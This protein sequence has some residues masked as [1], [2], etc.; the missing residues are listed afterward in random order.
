MQPVFQLPHPGSWQPPSSRF[1]SFSCFHKSS[2]V[3]TKRFIFLWFRQYLILTNDKYSQFS[4][5]KSQRVRYNYAIKE[6]NMHPL[7]NKHSLFFSS[8]KN[9]F[10]LSFEKRNI[11]RDATIRKQ[12]PHVGYPSFKSAWPRMQILHWHPKIFQNRFCVLWW[13][14]IYSTCE[15]HIQNHFRCRQRNWRN[16]ILRNSLIQKTKS[17][18]EIWDIRQKIKIRASMSELLWNSWSN[19]TSYKSMHC[20]RL[21]DFDRLYSP[22]IQEAKWSRIPNYK[23][24]M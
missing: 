17:S 22:Q 19:S 14:T 5:P 24:T 8:T 12:F 20:Q 13:W 1:M 15:K 9:I 16:I 2:S 21:S 23:I 11:T 7:G 4:A 18:I 3:T 6:F 10:P